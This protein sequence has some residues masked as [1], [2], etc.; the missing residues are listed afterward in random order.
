MRLNDFRRDAEQFR[1]LD[2]AALAAAEAKIFGPPISL[3]NIDLAAAEAKIFGPPIS[4]YTRAQ[5]I[6][7]GMLV[8]VSATAHEA[9]FRCPVAI[10]RAAWIDCV[11][12]TDADRTTERR[13]CQ[14]E[15]GRLWDVVWMAKLG[16]EGK[17][18]G[19]WRNGRAGIC[20]YQLRRVPRR[21]NKTIVTLK[22]H[23]RPGDDGEPVATIL[24]PE[25]E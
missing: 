9:G 24:F 1:D 20:Q 23:L 3:D 7:D 18:Y 10:T 19:D 25:E 22:V 11:Q 4:V 8:D 2:D 6:A 13:R 14:D 15:Q 16:L 12:W 17:W 21:G 5:A